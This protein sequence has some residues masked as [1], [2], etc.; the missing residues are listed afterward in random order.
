MDNF[1]K[2]VFTVVLSVLLRFLNW[3]FSAACYILMA[4]CFIPV[5]EKIVPEESKTIEFDLLFLGIVGVFWLAASFF[6][7]AVFRKNTDYSAD[8]ARERAKEKRS[9]SGYR[10]HR[11]WYS[12]LTEKVLKKA[13]FFY[14]LF[15]KINRLEFVF[16]VKS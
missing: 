4:V 11:F 16:N 8:A 5:W 10:P 2:I 6:Y 1:L 7:K 3:S 15:I 9:R 12:R 14:R 13:V